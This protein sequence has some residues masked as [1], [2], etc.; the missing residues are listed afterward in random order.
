MLDIMFE[1]PSRNDVA[2]VTVTE[3]T[4]KN[5]TAPIITNKTEE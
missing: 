3:D 2:K 5:K 4:V 1:I